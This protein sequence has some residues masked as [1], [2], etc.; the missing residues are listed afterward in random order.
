[1]RPANRRWQIKMKR[2]EVKM[3]PSRT[4]LLLVCWLPGCTSGL[5]QG[6]PSFE[7]ELLLPRTATTTPSSG[8]QS[9]SVYQ[10]ISTTDGQTVTTVYLPKDCQT[11]NDQAAAPTVTAPTNQSTLSIQAQ[12]RDN[13]VYA[14]KSII[15]DKYRVYRAA[16]HHLVNGG[17]AIADV[18]GLGLGLAGT[19]TPGE[20]AKTL[21]AAIGTTVAGARTAIDADYLYKQSIEMVINQ[22]DADRNGQFAVMIQEMTKDVDVYGYSEAM[23]DLLKYY[24]YGTWDH[25]I[26][27]LQTSTAANANA[28][29]AAVV[30]AKV[31]KA[32]GA[33]TPSNATNPST[34]NKVQTVTTT[35]A[36]KTINAGAS[37]G[38]TTSS[39]ATTPGCSPSIAASQ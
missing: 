24:A 25:A 26:T 35:S 1:M 5:W 19:I 38:T 14:L 16:M 10:Q 31:K 29:Q 3:K 13:C 22:M 7:T 8:G 12:N 28:C 6:A 33:L 15:D 39:P 27:S 2:G 34:S 30:T 37:P 17:N 9:S 20:A 4:A 23:D 18:A 11:D 21:L 36:N 32:T